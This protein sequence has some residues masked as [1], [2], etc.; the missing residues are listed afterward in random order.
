MKKLKFT[1]PVWTVPLLILLFTFTTA[2]L[3]VAVQPGSVYQSIYDIVSRPITIILNTFPVLV[4]VT[5]GYFISGNVF[6]G[7]SVTSLVA[8]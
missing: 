3:S 6:Y 2:V 4:L 1:L 8:L 5:L 7:A